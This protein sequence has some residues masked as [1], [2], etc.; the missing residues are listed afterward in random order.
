MWV[1]TV[2]SGSQ[3]AEDSWFQILGSC[4]PKL[5]WPVDVLVQGTREPPT[6]QNIDDRQLQMWAGMNLPLLAEVS[7]IYLQCSLIY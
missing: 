7:L 4:I 2:R 6:P 5:C 1:T 3:R